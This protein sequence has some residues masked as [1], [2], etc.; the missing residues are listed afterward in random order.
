MELKRKIKDLHERSSM[1][2][3][4]QLHSALIVWLQTVHLNCQLIR[5]KQ[6]RSVVAVWNPYH[7]QVEPWRCE[8]S[9]LPVRSFYLSNESAAIICPQFWPQNH[10]S[11][12][13]QN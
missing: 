5:K 7:K 8:Q 3:T 2:V 10:F 9:N 13:N 6:K 11:K 1:E 12:L 4:A